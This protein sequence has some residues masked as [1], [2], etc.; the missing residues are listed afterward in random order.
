MLAR[1]LLADPEWPNKAYKGDVKHIRPCIGCQEGCIQEFVDGGHPQCAVCARTAFE[2][3]FSKDI[4]P[5][6]TSK[7]VAVIGAGPAGVNVADVLLKRGHSVDLYDKNKKVG[8]TLIAASVPK[9][10][11]EL[12]NYVK[13]LEEVV[14]DL[15][16]NKKFNLYLDSEVTRELLK[17]KKYDAIVFATGSKIRV[18]AIEGLNG[19]NVHTVTEVLN[20]PSLVSKA[21]N[22]TIIGGG[23]SGCECAYM[24]AYELKKNVTIVEMMPTLMSSTCTAN[25]GH[26]L[27]YLEKANVNILNCTKLKAV[28]DGKVLVSR[29]V[30]KTVP[31]PFNTWQPILPENINNPLAKKIKEKFVDQEIDADVVIVAIGTVSENELYQTAVKEHLAKEIYNVGDSIKPGKVFMAVK[32]AYRTARDI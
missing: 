13:Y 19:K 8:G 31:T 12:L 21:Q 4:A 32:S 6:K 7:K 27:H 18:P 5:A 11:Y 22:V 20:K 9:I 10:K 16:K 3:E 24:M 15:S 23:D 2:E 25:R 29:N 28:K 17:E 14:A 26:L 1:P 30:S